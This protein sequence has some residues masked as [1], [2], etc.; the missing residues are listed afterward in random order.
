[1]ASDKAEALEMALAHAEAN[2]EDLSQEVRRQGLEITEL[3][4]EIGRITRS[5]EAML[6]RGDDDAP[7][8]NQPPPHW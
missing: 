4:K 7:P 3:R 2:I 5:L 8:V 1:M 6:E